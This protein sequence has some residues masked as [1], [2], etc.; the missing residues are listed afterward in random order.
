[1]NMQ[2]V[3]VNF[4]EEKPWAEGRYLYL[5][6]DIDDVLTDASIGDRDFAVG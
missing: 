1:M 5:S 3:I 6:V 2:V 4:A